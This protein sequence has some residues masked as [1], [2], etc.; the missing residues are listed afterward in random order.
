MLPTSPASSADAAA[1][2][3]LIYAYNTAADTLDIDGW[4]A[5]FT[6]TGVFRGAFDNFAAH[7]DKERF[8]AHARE[9]EAGGMPRL[10]HFMSNIRID[11]AGDRATSH[12]FFLI[13]A[14]PDSGPSTI[15]MVGEYRDTLSRAE[16]QWLFDERVVATDGASGGSRRAEEPAGAHATHRP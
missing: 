6:S 14:T 16:G 13:V 2:T 4:A 12:C 11:V 10:R 9:L 15:A 5:C 3:D 8:G 1:I 7:A